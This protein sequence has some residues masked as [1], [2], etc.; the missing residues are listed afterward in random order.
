MDIK[1][2]KK[3]TP[4]GAFCS[5][6]NKKLKNLKLCP[7]YNFDDYGKICVPS[8]CDHYKEVTK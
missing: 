1:N 8:M 5:A 4:P 6:A 7:I 2:G 3:E